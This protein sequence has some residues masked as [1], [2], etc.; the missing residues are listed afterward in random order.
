[1]AV[2]FGNINLYY[3]TGTMQDSMLF[4]PRDDEAVLWVRKSYERAKAESDFRL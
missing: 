2:I 3:L 4:I 1:M